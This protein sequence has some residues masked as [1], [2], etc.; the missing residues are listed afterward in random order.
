[1]IR[2]NLLPES[3][4]RAE[5]TSPKVFAAALI[6]V[7]LVCSS[8]G[9]FGMVYFGELEKMVVKHKGVTETL[10]AV[11]K[12][13]THYDNLVRERKEFS[14]RKDTIRSIA[15][16]RMIWT[17]FMDELITVVTNEG[18]YDRHVAWFNSIQVRGSRDGRKGPGVV[19]PGAVQGDDIR[20]IANIIDD[21]EAANFYQN[22]AAPSMPSGVKK[23]DAGVFPPESFTFSWRWQF[24]P[25]SKWVKNR[26]GAKPET[27]E[28]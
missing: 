1:M 10:T 12:R 20:K 24:L 9:W 28:K 25:P 15:R 16:G 18:N 2:I 26:V 3:Y 21:V 27:P 5:R 8:L 4:R 6:G 14:Q 19:M 11:K 22:I 7:I 13:A 17:Q 23:I